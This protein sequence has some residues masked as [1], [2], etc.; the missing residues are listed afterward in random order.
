MAMLIG[1]MLSISK[2][3]LSVVRAAIDYHMLF[4]FT[5][6]KESLKMLFSFLFLLLATGRQTAALH[7]LTLV[8]A[9]S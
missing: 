9:P 8:S 3:D 6:H 4:H 5:S 1:Q 2:G 7:D